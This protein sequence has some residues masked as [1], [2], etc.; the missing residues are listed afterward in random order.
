MDPRFKWDMSKK[1]CMGG[2][3][4]LKSILISFSEKKNQW[5]SILK[6]VTKR[7]PMWE[8]HSAAS[9][10]WFSPLPRWDVLRKL[11]PHRGVSA[12]HVVQWSRGSAPHEGALHWFQWRHLRVQLRLLHERDHGA[13][14]ALHRVPGGWRHAVQLRVWPWHDMWGVRWRHVLGPGELSGALH[15][16]RHLRGRRGPQS[17]HLSLGYRL[18]G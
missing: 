17:L 9:Y 6:C 15:P 14:R 4:K 12:L 8:S 3:A 11:Q 16:L 2:T 18:R 5:R 13:V 7:F 1:I 10:S